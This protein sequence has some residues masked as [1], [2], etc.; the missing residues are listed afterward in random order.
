MSYPKWQYFPSFVQAPSWVDEFIDVISSH[1]IE[2]DSQSIANLTSDRVLSFIA[3]DLAR[4]GYQVETG[5][6]A[7]QKIR[8]PVLYGE[9]GIEKVSYE[10]DAFNDSI[11]IAVEIEAGRGAR[12]NAVYRDLIRTSLIVGSKYLIL[13]VM[14]EYRHQSSGKEVVV[15]SFDDARSLV[16]AIFSSGRLGLPFEGILLVG[17]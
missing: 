7:L 3:D 12:G 6:R 13:G 14:I 2:I 10:I 4:L 5:K 11:G 1:R 17:Y 16:E 15:R 8:R 9:E